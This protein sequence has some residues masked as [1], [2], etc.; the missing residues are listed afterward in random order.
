MG[1]T[2]L[3]SHT[4][5][6]VLLKRRAK[7]MRSEQTPA[8]QK[9]WSD[10]R[11]LKSQGFHF[12]RQV[13][14]PPYIVDFV[15]HKN[16]II[17]EV[18]GETHMTSKAKRYDEKRDMFLESQGYTVLRFSNDSVYDCS[19]RVIDILCDAAGIDPHPQSLPTGGREAKD[20]ISPLKTQI[21][22]GQHG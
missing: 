9:L 14:F 12:R 15:C 11:Q 4:E 19:D 18:D 20:L 7:S 8:E 5:I 2:E 10:L 3:A 13:V 6:P 22:E 1:V 17:I 16:K 21:I